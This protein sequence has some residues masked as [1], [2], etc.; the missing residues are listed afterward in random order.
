[1]PHVAV[2][3]LCESKA[4]T[5]RKGHQDVRGFTRYQRC[6]LSDILL[7]EDHSGEH[8]TAKYPLIDGEPR[9]WTAF[10]E[11]WDCETCLLST[12]NWMKILENNSSH[13]RVSSII[14]FFHYPRESWDA[15][16]ARHFQLGSSFI[17]LRC[18][19]LHWRYQMF[20][21]DQFFGLR[22]TE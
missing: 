12:I 11:A 7:L 22:A 6:D 15:G 16:T 20:D 18:R 14:I 2:A 19:I 5:S 13:S 1:M 9:S 4:D 8:Y 3:V 21:L 17:K 10:S